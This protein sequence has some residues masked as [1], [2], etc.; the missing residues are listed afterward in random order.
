MPGSL[1]FYTQEDESYHVGGKPTVERDA[2]AALR[3]SISPRVPLP[4]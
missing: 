3:G 1:R 4:I 2:A